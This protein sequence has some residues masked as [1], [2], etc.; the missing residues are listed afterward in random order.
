MTP[1]EESWNK[2]FDLIDEQSKLGKVVIENDEGLFAMSLDKMCEQ[3]A[4]GILYDTNRLEEVTK[5]IKS[6][7]SVNDIAMAKIVR[8]L[9]NRVEYLETELA[10][11]REKE[12]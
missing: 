5:T 10:K 1:T 9:K 3:F 6:E 4:D 11:Y 2:I 7:R 8:Y 12:E